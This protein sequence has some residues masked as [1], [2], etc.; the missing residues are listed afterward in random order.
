[1]TIETNP[2]GNVV[3]PPAKAE[4]KF[5]EYEPVN[6]V[7]VAWAGVISKPTANKAAAKARFLMSEGFMDVL[8][9]DSDWTWSRAANNAD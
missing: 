4:S 6:E 2:G 8:N 9:L 5:C 7:G 3:A 1:M